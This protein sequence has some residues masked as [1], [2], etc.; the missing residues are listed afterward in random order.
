MFVFIILLYL[1]HLVSI[2]RK[3]RRP[4]GD[5]GANDPRED[6]KKMMRADILFAMAGLVI[7]F[8]VSVFLLRLDA[9]M[10]SVVIFLVAVR[11]TPHLV[12][13]YRD[14]QGKHRP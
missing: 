3:T 14:G 1:P 5:G 10:T 2:L 6:P 9:M 7:A 4:L 8:L 11:Y 13:R 12:Q